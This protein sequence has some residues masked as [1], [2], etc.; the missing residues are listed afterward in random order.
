VSNKSQNP[1]QVL[2]GNIAHLKRKLFV[3]EADLPALQRARD[4]ANLDY[5]CCRAAELV[6]KADELAL[7]GRK[8][9]GA[10]QQIDNIKAAI[11]QAEQQLERFERE[12][13]AKLN[14][15][16]VE[17]IGR[18]LKKANADV[19]ALADHLT[20]AVE[21]Y[22]AI[23]KA[24][25]A[26]KQR[27]KFFPEWG[28]GTRL[29]MENLI[30]AELYRLSAPLVVPALPSKQAY[31]RAFPGA[32]APS[33]EFW[34]KPASIEPMAKVFAENVEKVMRHLAGETFDVLMKSV[35]SLQPSHS[36]AAADLL[37]NQ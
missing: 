12:C 8:L 30:C 25:V 33:Q 28:V 16:V 24:V 37:E 20:K 27:S 3:A 32:E 26:A 9:A 29:A 2:E 11:K 1:R 14:R 15:T 6:T 34:D 10:K 7:A 19:A 4:T 18:D 35:P 36:A 23:S 22:I 5:Q 13:A 31:D 17:S 21:L